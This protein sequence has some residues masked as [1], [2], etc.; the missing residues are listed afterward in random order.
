MNFFFSEI[1]QNRQKTIVGLRPVP[2]PC[3]AVHCPPTQVGAKCLAA[4][5]LDNQD[6]ALRPFFLLLSPSW[7]FK[8][9]QTICK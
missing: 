8:L 5:V 2:F 9:N 4:V 3:G 6:R 7:N 1:D